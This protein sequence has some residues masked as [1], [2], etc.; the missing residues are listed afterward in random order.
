MKKCFLCGLEDSIIDFNNESF[1]NC[2]LKLLFRREKNFVHGE[3]RLCLDSIDNVG[4]HST[5]YK[6]VT[7]LSKKYNDEYTQFCKKRVVSI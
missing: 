4:Y 3:V 7:V 2:F 1:K 6:K 5:C